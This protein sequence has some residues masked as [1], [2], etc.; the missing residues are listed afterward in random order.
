MRTK[1]KAS[2]NLF[3]TKH[4]SYM[5]I[6]YYTCFAS[7]KTTDVGFVSLFSIIKLI[8]LKFSFCTNNLIGV[9]ISS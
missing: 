5:Y 9:M 3:A 6:M 2:G 8:G 1:N 4:D 7:T